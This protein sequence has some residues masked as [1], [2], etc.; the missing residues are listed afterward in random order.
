[1][2]L[3]FERAVLNRIPQMEA[4]PEQYF[5]QVLFLCDE[6]QHFATVGESDPSGD[7]KAFALSR[8]AKCIPIVATQSISS[9]RSAL[10]GESWRTLLQTFRTK[11][12]LCL[13]DDFSARIASELC[14]REDRFKVSYNLSESGHNARVSLLTGKALSH[15]SNISASK[16]YSTQNDF[17]F[18]MKTFMELRNGQSVA[19][20]YDGVN[21]LPPM[22][23]YLKP[24][25]NDPNK[26]YFQQLADGDL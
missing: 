3:D 18:D 10:P 24:Y 25:Y 7:E 12:V 22:F 4:H 1:M 14:G 13:S 11:V 17:R 9:L 26:S 16:S 23:C 15:R 6:Y 20:A 19:I 5:R 2:K 8:Q 21:P